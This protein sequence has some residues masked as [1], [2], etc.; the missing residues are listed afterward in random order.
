ML[1]VHPSVIGVREFNFVSQCLTVISSH[2]WFIL[3][4]STQNVNPSWNT[5][6]WAEVY[7]SGYPHSIHG[8][9]PDNESIKGRVLI[10]NS[11]HFRATLRVLNCSHLRVLIELW[12]KFESNVLSVVFGSS[13]PFI[14][15]AMLNAVEPQNTV[16]FA[17]RDDMKSH[18]KKKHPEPVVTKGFCCQECKKPFQYELALHLHEERCGKEKAKPFKYT[19]AGCG[20]CFSRKST[21][22]HHQ[23]HFHLSQQGSDVKR[24]LDQETGE[25]KRVRPDLPKKI[26]EKGI[27]NPSS[28]KRTLEQ[29]IR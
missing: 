28:V 19:F 10:Q 14:F 9:T 1:T 16:T 25:V 22:E 26:D 20:K 5:E 24:T 7:F 11:F 4:V 27:P 17:R 2:L 29:E 15:I 18:I 3:N 8:H 13:I 21:L 6:R 23:Q 12:I